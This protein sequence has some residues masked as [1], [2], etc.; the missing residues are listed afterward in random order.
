M[1][2]E[3]DTTGTVKRPWGADDI[4]EPL[5]NSW[6]PSLDFLHELE[7]DSCIILGTLTLHLNY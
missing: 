5:N 1:G 4:V 6:V 2:T 7:T 3:E